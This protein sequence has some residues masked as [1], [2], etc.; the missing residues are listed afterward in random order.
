MEL[1]SDFYVS[2]LIKNYKQMEKYTDEP[3]ER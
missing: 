1:K 2:M 3:N